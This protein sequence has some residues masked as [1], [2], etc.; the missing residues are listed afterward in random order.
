MASAWGASWGASWG[1]SWG[2]RSPAGGNVGTGFGRSILEI[3]WRNAHL[4][5]VE[6]ARLPVE[7][8]EVAGATEAATPS[9]L[10]WRSDTLPDLPRLVHD[11][12]QRRLAALEA[13]KH[14][15]AAMLREAMQEEED[16][17]IA[18]LMWMEES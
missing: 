12:F 16:A 1:N 6:R 17:A 14:G 5:A 18:M 8:A 15:A 10:D 9:A 11:E 2:V 13:A 3:E 4:R 7:N